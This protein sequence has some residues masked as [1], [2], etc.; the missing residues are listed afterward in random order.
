M[1]K[2]L[3]I[4]SNALCWAAFHGLPALSH[5]EFGTAIIYGFLNKLFTIQRTM[6]ADKIVFAWDDAHSKRIELFPEYKYKRRHS[7]EEYTPDEKEMHRDRVRQFHLLHDE[8]V[9]SLGFVNNFKEYGLEGDDII[10]SVA[11]AHDKKHLVRI[12]ARDGDLYQLIT[13]TCS[14]Y[15]PTT[16]TYTD[17]EKFFTKYGIYPDMWGDVKGL[18]GCTGDEVPGVQGIGTDRAIK[19]LLGNMK[20]TSVLYKRIQSSPDVVELTRKLVVLPFEGTPTFKLKDDKCKVKKL[21]KVARKYGLESY[22]SKERII[23]FRRYFCN[24]TKKAQGQS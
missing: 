11:K 9:P 15:D 23:Q 20:V 22:L 14:M 13:P 21:K 12:V 5:K 6:E 3:I 17:E 19:Y 8:I 1:S 2:I 24:G 16:F 4:D 7:K 18:A 10:A